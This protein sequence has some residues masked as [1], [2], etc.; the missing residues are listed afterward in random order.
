MTTPVNTANP[1][2]A[3]VAQPPQP[4]ISSPVTT[5]KMN[6]PASAPAGGWQ[7][8]FKQVGW[9]EVGFTILGTAALLFLI[10]YYRYRLYAEKESAKKMQS[11]MDDLTAK[12]AKIETRMK[13]PVKKR[14]GF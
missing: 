5:V 3:S 1:M 12:V 4:P 7:Q 6:Q 10:R 8:F 2:E 13:Q 14:T 11:E 9:V